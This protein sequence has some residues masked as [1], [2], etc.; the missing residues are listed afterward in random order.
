MGLVM[1]QTRLFIMLILLIVVLL[2]A[3]YNIMPCFFTEF[4]IVTV[5]CV[6]LGTGQIMAAG[7]KRQTEGCKEMATAQ[8]QIQHE[9]SSCIRGCNGNGPLVSSWRCC[10]VQ[11]FQGISR[12]A[13]AFVKSHLLLDIDEEG[14]MEEFGLKRSG[15]D[16]SSSNKQDLGAKSEFLKELDS[17]QGSHSTLSESKESIMCKH[18]R[19]TVVADKYASHSPLNCAHEEDYETDV[20]ELEDCSTSSEEEVV[21]KTVLQTTALATGAHDK[22]VSEDNMLQPTTPFIKGA[23]V[24]SDEDENSIDKHQILPPEGCNNVYSNGFDLVDLFGKCGGSSATRGLLKLEIT[25]A[26]LQKA[27]GE[28]Y[29]L[30]GDV[31]WSESDRKKQQD[32]KRLDYVSDDL[33]TTSKQCELCRHGYEVAS[34]EDYSIFPCKVQSGVETIVSMP[35]KSKIVHHVDAKKAQKE[36][37]RSE[38]SVGE[39]AEIRL[40][41]EMDE[42]V[43]IDKELRAIAFRSANKG[44]D[45]NY[46]STVGSFRDFVGSFREFDSCW[47]EYSMV[48]RREEGIVTGCCD[49]HAR[50]CISHSRSRSK[51]LQSD[52]LLSKASLLREQEIM[53]VLWQEYNEDMR[54]R[55]SNCGKQ[56]RESAQKQGLKTRGESS[57]GGGND[58][59]FNDGYTAGPNPNQDMGPSSVPDYYNCDRNSTNTCRLGCDKACWHTA[60]ERGYHRRRHFVGICKVLREL[61]LKQCIQSSKVDG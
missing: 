2:T 11:G 31:L 59:V 9:V 41:E 42:D 53:D 20:P 15:D 7:V 44:E 37:G 19:S 3:L 17:A 16:E 4:A 12:F 32:G 61:G 25:D 24:C 58:G 13:L 50:P 30:E 33:L 1:I 51:V 23:A 18:G 6:V 56:Q 47:P 10:W 48:G 43:L 40:V 45:S 52:P 36:A 26:E 46:M 34:S 22:E 21:C 49:D 27:S 39:P 38:K 57:G 14:L 35:A 54:Q 5:I 60:K 28:F 55:W 29:T 8:M